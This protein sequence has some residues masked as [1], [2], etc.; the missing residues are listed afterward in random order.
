MYYTYAMA[1]IWGG[2]REEHL[3]RHDVTIAMAQEAEADPK[4][5]R[6][7]P[8]PASISGA[9]IRTIGHSASFGDLLSVLSYIDEDGVEQGSTAYL[10]KGKFRRYYHEGQE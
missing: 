7:V 5:V 8:D 3:A 10:A 1:M 9:G 6:L 2:D 4:A